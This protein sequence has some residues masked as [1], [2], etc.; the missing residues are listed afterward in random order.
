MLVVLASAA[1][2]EEPVELDT[3]ANIRREGGAG[4]W[5]TKVCVQK[6]PTRFSLLQISFFR[7]MVTLVLGGGAGSSCGGRPC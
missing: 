4:V 5:D 2:R 6:W 1:K 3:Q 7:T